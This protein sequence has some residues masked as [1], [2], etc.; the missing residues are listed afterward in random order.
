MAQPLFGVHVQL[1][2]CFLYSQNQNIHSI[3]ISYVFTLYVIIF[4]FYDFYEH[5]FVNNLIHLLINQ[6]NH[7][8]I[9]IFAQKHKIL[10]SGI[11]FAFVFFC[12]KPEPSPKQKSHIQNYF[13]Y[14][15]SSNMNNIFLNFLRCELI[16]SI[17]F[18]NINCYTDFNKNFI[19][20]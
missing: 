9:A 13:L 17:L 4:L 12:V 7:Y 8:C 20:F 16:R 2:F 15:L 18:V 10:I 3:I 14:I 1:S 19:R 11:L 5:I 6:N